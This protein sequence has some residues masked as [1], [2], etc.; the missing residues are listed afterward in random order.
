MQ[1]GF[2]FFQE[3]SA[4]AEDLIPVQ[5]PDRAGCQD[6]L[7]HTH[8]GLMEEHVLVVIES[9]GAVQQCA[10]VDSARRN[11]MWGFLNS[12]TE[13]FRRALQAKL[14]STSQVSQGLF[15]A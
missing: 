10:R 15:C 13:C 7:H 9:F 1:L 4:Q 12:R 3:H 5:K 8:K 14:S 2:A 6:W 11:L